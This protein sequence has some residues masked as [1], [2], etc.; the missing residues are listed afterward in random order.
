MVVFDSL[1]I[2]KLSLLGLFVSYQIGYLYIK[3]LLSFL[4]HKINLRISQ[5]P[6]MHGITQPQQMQI[7]GILNPLL[8]IIRLA[9]T[10]KFVAY[11]KV[12]EIVLV[13]AL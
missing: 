5:L 9:R 7:H 3:G 12:L 1:Q 2:S 4:C 10:D 6:D 8:N 13:V 11:S